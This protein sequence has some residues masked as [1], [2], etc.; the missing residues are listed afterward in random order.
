MEHH[1]EQQDD[2]YASG[3]SMETILLGAHTECPKGFR[4]FFGASSVAELPLF[5]KY[6]RISKTEK[7]AHHEEKHNENAG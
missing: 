3:E 2:I 4:S 6:P 5:Y 7:E 1:S